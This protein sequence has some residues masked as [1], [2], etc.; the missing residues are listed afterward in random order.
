MVRNI[1][2]KIVI[3]E[4]FGTHARESHD[5]HGTIISIDSENKYVIQFTDGETSSHGVSCVKF[6]SYPEY[7]PDLD[8]SDSDRYINSYF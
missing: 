1:G 5:R 7:D 2:R 6:H 3:T 8:E 4:L